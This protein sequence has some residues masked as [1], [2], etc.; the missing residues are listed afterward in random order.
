MH[1]PG[2]TQGR[3]P[4]ESGLHGCSLVDLDSDGVIRCRFL[5][6]TTVRWENFDLDIDADTTF[7]QLVQR[8]QTTCRS[9]CGVE[10][11][12]EPGRLVSEYGD[13]AE[14]DSKPDATAKDP[15]AVSGVLHAQACFLRLDDSR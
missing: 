7:Q 12:A 9:L 5:P 15:A 4:E 13:A 6:T 1:F 3:T 8:A 2:S 11:K 10:P 14:Y